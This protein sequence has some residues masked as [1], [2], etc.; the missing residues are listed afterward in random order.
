MNKDSFTCNGFTVHTKTYEYKDTYGRTVVLI[1]MIHIGSKK[2]YEKVETILKD[3]N[4]ILNEGIN[5]HTDRLP[6]NIN[7]ETISNVTGL[8]AQKP[9]KS[10]HTVNGDGDVSDLSENTI[11]ALKA[12]TDILDGGSEKIS[13]LKNLRKPELLHDILD[14]RNKTLEEC[15]N[16]VLSNQKFIKKK[17]NKDRKTKKTR[18]HIDYKEMFKNLHNFQQLMPREQRI[19]I[20]WDAKHIP[21]FQEMVDNKNFTLKATNKIYVLNVLSVIFYIL[22]YPL[23]NK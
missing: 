8:D 19:Y 13:N 11:E 23:R 10:T 20:P 22:L 1:P 18:D 3:S 17:L 4:M 21:Y 5:D 16:S 9:F 15:F 14:S 7:Y 12:I 6:K 2:F